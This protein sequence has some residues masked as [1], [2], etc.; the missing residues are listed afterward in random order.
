MRFRSLTV[1]GAGLGLALALTSCVH[2]SQST[3]GSRYLAKYETQEATAGA[4]ATVTDAQI[5]QAAAVEPTLTFPA[6][7]GLARIDEGRLSVIPTA[8]AA[9]WQDLGARLG[10]AWGQFVPVSPL[11]A[12]VAS[13]VTGESACRRPEPAYHRQREREAAV[14]F[15]CL[16]ETMQTIRL[17][18]ARQHLDAVLIYESF[19]RSQDRTNPL[20]I[21][22]LALIGFFL[23]TENV[24][25][26]GLAQ[27]VLVDVRSGYHYGTA[28]AAADEPAH[29]LST[30]S[31][32]DTA[33]SA[34]QGEARLAAVTALTA[35]VE[36]MAVALRRDLEGRAGGASKRPAAP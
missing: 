14:D 17:G 24:E 11:V 10:P 33:H 23:P 31:N 12:A 15:D 28:T 27:A 21:T 16:R 9:V 18:A 30:Q 26:Q 8:E 32:V 1:L 4:P 34:A 36:K 6:R 5:L 20:A 7:I 3:S 13:P 2:S 35:E 19:G 29:R 25:A 22:Q